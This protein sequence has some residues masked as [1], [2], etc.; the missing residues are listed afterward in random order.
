VQRRPPPFA[1]VAGESHHVPAKGL[2]TGIGQFLDEVAN[3]L[4][5]GEWKG[6]PAAEAVAQ[7]FAARSVS[8]RQAAREPALDLSAIL[9]CPE[10]HT[11]DNGVHT[12]EGSGPVLQALATNT[13]GRAIVLVKRRTQTLINGVASYISVNPQIPSWRLFLADVHR[14]I[15]D[16]GFR[17]QHAMKPSDEKAVDLILEHAEK[18]FMDAEEDAQSFLDDRVGKRTNKVLDR[19]VSDAY[20]AGKRTVRGAMDRAQD[21][22]PEGRSAALSS[23]DGHFGSSWAQFRDPI[24]VSYP[25]GGSQ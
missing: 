2:G 19:A 7:E 23:L 8:N 5:G 15:N 13:K 4:K 22:T 25:A 12:V 17:N 18:E 3:K 14:A 10:A 21:G 20:Q 16:V 1:N 24:D 11:E 9:L 6:D